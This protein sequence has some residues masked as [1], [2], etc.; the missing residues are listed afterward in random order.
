MFD[1]NWLLSAT[2][3]S[4]AAIVAI[5]GGFI[6]TRLMTDMDQ[7]KRNRSPHQRY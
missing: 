3:Q 7:K 4:T 6:A 1:V 2:A 5:L